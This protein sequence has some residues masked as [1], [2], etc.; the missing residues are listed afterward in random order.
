MEV[1]SIKLFIP[2]KGDLTPRP[3]RGRPTR[4]NATHPPIGR[5]TRQVASPGGRPAQ[6]GHIPPGGRPTR[7]D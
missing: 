3:P 4:Q 2:P 1:T 6:T 5:P 7:Q